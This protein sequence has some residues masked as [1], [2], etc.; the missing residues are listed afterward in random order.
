MKSKYFS[1]ERLTNNISNWRLVI[2][3][4]IMFPFIIFG[5]DSVRQQLI[6]DQ[7]FSANFFEPVG[8]TIRPAIIIV[9]GSG[10]G[11]GWQNYMGEILAQHGF[12]TLALAYFKM[13]DLPSELEEIPL[14]YFDRAASWLQKQPRVDSTKVGIIGISKGAELVLLLGS[15]SSKFKA[16]V[17]IAPSSVAFQSITKNWRETSSWSHKGEPL[18][19]V[20]YLVNEK[21]NRDTLAIMYR[22]SLTQKEVVDSAVIKVENATGPIL[23]ISGEGD[24]LWPSTEMSQNIIKRLKEHSY[25]YYYNHIS[26]PN[27]GH[28]I[29]T[30]FVNI[31]E[32]K[33]W[34]GTETGNGIAQKDAQKRVIRFFKDYLR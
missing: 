11:I 16:I 18:P 24:T 26:Y 1:L 23:L 7:E 13:E 15:L 31:K 17:A 30:I 9:G 29:G 19:F 25:P 2:I 6:I 14:E 10:G 8:D 21:F 28:S 27:A 20:P 4:I 33:L 34:G 3:I 32:W 5:Q 22:E 12:A